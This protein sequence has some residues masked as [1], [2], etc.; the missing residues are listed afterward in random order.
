MATFVKT[1]AAPG[2]TA[3]AA[4][5]VGHYDIVLDDSDVKAILAG[6][7]VQVRVVL[8]PNTPIHEQNV[9]TIYRQAPAAPVTVPVPTAPAPVMSPPVTEP[10]AAPPPA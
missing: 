10:P 5:D 9:V 7:P 1:N 3:G 8:P 6:H 2:E 4:T